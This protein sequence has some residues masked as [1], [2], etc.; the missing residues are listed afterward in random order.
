MKYL[1]IS[2]SVASLIFAISY[3]TN[4]QPGRGFGKG[5][6]RGGHGPRHD[7]RFQADHDVFH[8]LLTNHKKITRKVTKLKNGVETVTESKNP[9]IAEKIQEHVKWMAERV[10]KG[11]PTRMRD[12]LF[13]ELFR[14]ADKIEIETTKTKNGI[15]VVET[16]KDPKV[17]RLI[18]A[19][20]EVVTGFVNRGL[21]E[22]MKNHAVPNST[23]A[24]L[25]FKNPKIKKYG[26][27]IHFPEAAQQPRANTKIVVDITAGG[28]QGELYSSIDKL[29]RFVNIYKGAGKEAHDVKIAVVMHGNATY[30]ALNSDA[31]AKKFNVNSNANLDCLHELHEAGVELYVC[32]QSLVHKGG[33]QADVAIFID[34]AVSG[35]TSIVNLQQ[36]GYTYFPLF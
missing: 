12:P 27:V 18:Q 31:Y 1:I 9:K 34:T 32:G 6:G 2:A 33:M 3:S 20:A 8:F 22:A 35:L 30:A 26:G 14:H 28:E 13:A 29:A 7:E 19:H 11:K 21:A 5:P 15:K 17:A 10:E 23:R 36:D 16:S 25:K 4:A 24:S